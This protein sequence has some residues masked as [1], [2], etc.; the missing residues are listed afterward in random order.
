MKNKWLHFDID[1]ETVFGL[2]CGFVMILLSMA[3]TFFSGEISSIIL[4]DILMILL[5]GFLTPVYYIL[6]VKKKSLSVLGIHTNKLAASLAIN[7]AAAVSLLALFISKNTEDIRF[8]V[9]SFYAVTYILAAGVFEMV[10]IYGFL[11][12]ECE[13]A[14][15]I[16]PAVFLTAVFY[17]LHHAGFQPEFAKLFFVG[18]MYVSVFYFTHNIFSIFPFFWGVGAVW[19]VLVHSEAG[20]QLKNKTSFVIAM[21]L[22]SAMT[23]ISV[24]IRR[25]IRKISNLDTGG[26]I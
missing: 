9:H 6:I 15:G 12:Y 19:D 4:R 16:L 11:R 10:F 3:M 26:K 25:K 17:S 21:L 7:A 1:K 23:G 20:S 18:I 13:R 8:T 22:F 14:F 2:A 5:F 24:C